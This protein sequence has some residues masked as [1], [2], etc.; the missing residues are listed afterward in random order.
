VP[1]TTLFIYH[2]PSSFSQNQNRIKYTRIYT[3]ILVFISISLSFSFL[4]FLHIHLSLSPHSL[5]TPLHTC[6]LAF[7]SPHRASEKIIETRRWPGL[8]GV[9]AS[10]VIHANHAEPSHLSKTCHPLSPLHPSHDPSSSLHPLSCHLS[11][12]KP[13]GRPHP[14]LTFF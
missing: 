4:L 6:A 9:Q 13:H 11:F 5:T 2:L 10:H 14:F 1:N 3:L 8:S 12:G 7:H